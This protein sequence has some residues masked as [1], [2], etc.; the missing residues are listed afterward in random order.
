MNNTAN[1]RRKLS[2][3]IRAKSTPTKN[4]IFDVFVNGH[5]V[6]LEADNIDYIGIDSLHAFNCVLD[7]INDISITL[8]NKEP[9][10]T[11][12]IDGKITED[13]MLIIE[14]LKID[15][16]DLTSKLSKLS[17]YVSTDGIS[18]QTHG[19]VSFNGTMK[20]KVHNNLLYTELLSSFI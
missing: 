19:Y 14:S 5:A 15:H 9:G 12:V 10:D 7:N 4:P 20:F 3:L 11:K 16:I 13:L 18:H 6:R 17:N 1:N 2:L 8:T